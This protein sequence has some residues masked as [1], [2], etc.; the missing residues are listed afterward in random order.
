MDNLSQIFRAIT[1]E[2]NLFGP[3][4]FQWLKFLDVCIDNKLMRLFFRL[5]CW[6][7]RSL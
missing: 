7:L 3:S 1:I 2:L 4:C 5:K 6:A